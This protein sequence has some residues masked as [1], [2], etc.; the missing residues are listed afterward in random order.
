MSLDGNVIPGVIAGLTSL[1]GGPTSGGATVKG[2]LASVHLG[3][4]W[5]VSGRGPVAWVLPGSF[6]EPDRGSSNMEMTSWV[7]EVRLLY[8]FANDQ[9]YAEEQLMAL[10]EPIRDVFR[11]HTKLAWVSAPGT[12]QPLNSPITPIT[13]TRVG[14]GNWLYIVVAKRMYRMLVLNVLVGEKIGQTYQPGG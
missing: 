10:V 14:G 6:S 9:R 2:R 3:E 5:A 11:K 13:T 8:E 7:I 1:V 4:Q 12:G